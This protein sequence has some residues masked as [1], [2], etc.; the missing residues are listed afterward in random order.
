MLK[1]C[2]PFLLVLFFI[3]CSPKSFRFDGK[4]LQQVAVTDMGDLYSTYKF[5][6]AD[7]Q[8]L[9]AQFQNKDVVSQIITY[10]KE[11]N[12]PDAIN[13]LEKRLKARATLL[14]YRF[15]KVAVIG[16]KTILTLPP[17]KNRHMPYGFVP[18]GIMYMVIKS[19]SVKAL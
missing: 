13:S 14:R 9:G 11:E 2:T 7:K 3:S 18:A 17:Q 10:S 12:W 6:E 19:S 1:S 15:Y 4:K 16:N 8:E 5:T